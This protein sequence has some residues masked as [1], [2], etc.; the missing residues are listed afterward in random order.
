MKIRNFLRKTMI[1]A[2]CACFLPLYTARAETNICFVAIDD[3]LP[4]ELNGS[5]MP[6]WDGGELYVAS[7][8]FENASLGVYSSYDKTEWIYSL[9]N[10]NHRLDFYLT[11]M[12]SYDSLGNYYEF[13]ALTRNDRVFVPCSFVCAFFGLNFAYITDG[14][15]PVVRITT[16]KQ[17]YTASQFVSNAASI[18]SSRA[19]AYLGGNSTPVSGQQPAQDPG[20]QPEQEPDTNKSLALW[21]EVGQCDYVTRAAALLQEKKLEATWFYSR[22]AAEK[23]QAE[24][25][26]LS[27]MGASLAVSGDTVKELKRV[28]DLLDSL[29]YARTRLACTA[30]GDM[31]GAGYIPLTWDVDADACLEQPETLDT[32]EDSGTIVVLHITPESHTYESFANFIDF[33]V[34]SDYHIYPLDETFYRR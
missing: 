10:S 19:A 22:T 27:R 34:N 7:S 18:I 11:M 3:T 2:L 23:G 17:V 14:A 25:R 4:F 33:I 15:Y 26:E 5:T 24:L 20:Q 8:V 12:A 29:L 13:K 1:F 9:Y 16:G 21:L 30:E 6:F 32:G 28:N 31:S